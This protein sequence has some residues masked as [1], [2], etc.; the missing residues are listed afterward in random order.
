MLINWGCVGFVGFIFPILQKEV[1]LWACFLIFLLMCLIGLVIV[2]L[3]LKE[4]K[5][6]GQSEIEE[7]YNDKKDSLMELSSN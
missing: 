4:T 2:M 7:L 6:L 5:G 3:Y 1:A